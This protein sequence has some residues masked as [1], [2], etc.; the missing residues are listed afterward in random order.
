MVVIYGGPAVQMN[1]QLI[2]IN[3]QLSQIPQFRA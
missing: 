2:L 3:F 1:L